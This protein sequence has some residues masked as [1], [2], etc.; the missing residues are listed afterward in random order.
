MQ[1]KSM[2]CKQFKED[3]QPQKKVNKC[4][5]RICVVDQAARVAFLTLQI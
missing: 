3:A 4:L 2:E 5:R 1:S